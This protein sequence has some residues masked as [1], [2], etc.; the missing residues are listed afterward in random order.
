MKFTK[1]RPRA[2]FAPEILKLET[3]CARTVSPGASQKAGIMNAVG[4]LAG[5]WMLSTGAAAEATEL[6]LP[7]LDPVVSLGLERAEVLAEPLPPAA[8]EIGQ[9]TVPQR[10]WTVPDETPISHGGGAFQY[11]PPQQMREVCE[12]IPQRPALDIAYQAID[13]D[14]AGKSRPA[15][16][17][18]YGAGDDPV[19]GRPENWNSDVTP[20]VSERHLEATR[21]S[22][23][24]PSVTTTPQEPGAPVYGFGA[25][26]PLVTALRQIV[27]QDRHVAYRPGLPLGSTVSW[28]GGEGWRIVLHRTLSPLNLTFEERG[29]LIYVDQAGMKPRNRAPLNL[30]SAPGT[31]GMETDRQ[32]YWVD[33]RLQPAR[34]DMQAGFATPVDLTPTLPREN[35]QLA[36]APGEPVPQGREGVGRA[37]LVE[38]GLTLREVLESWGA[39]A[40]WTIV[41]SSERD[42]FIEASAAFSGEFE[43]AAAELVRA[44][45][46]AEPPVIATFYRNRTVVIETQSDGDTE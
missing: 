36:Q 39:A 6:R 13:P 1:A 17:W 19:D 40:G 35:R 28:Q 45:S 18:A 30:A 33:G 4:F 38:R 24:A 12:P 11:V 31:G 41:W 10:C 27:P 25:E 43:Q 46:T 26:L 15:A 23:A 44:F 8:V 22:A 5:S 29:R 2:G 42:Y 14:A 21:A 9:E 20:R 34:G 32:D 37:W 16:S 7:P 3:G